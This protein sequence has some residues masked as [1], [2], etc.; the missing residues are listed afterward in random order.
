M[1]EDYY[2]GL[3]ENCPWSCGLCEGRSLHYTN[4]PLLP[5][6]LPHPHCAIHHAKLVCWTTSFFC[7][8]VLCVSFCVVAFQ[9]VYLSLLTSLSDISAPPSPYAGSP[10]GGSEVQA[11]QKLSA[12]GTMVC[13]S[14]DSVQQRDSYWWYFGTI[15][16]WDASTV[17]VDKGTY[18]QV[19]IKLA[20]IRHTSVPLGKAVFIDPARYRIFSPFPHLTGRP[21]SLARIN[22]KPLPPFLF[23]LSL[24]L[25]VYNCRHTHTQ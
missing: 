18:G 25:V 20:A 19:K 14:S 17:Y 4:P 2:A 10:M 8:V 9:H 7:L 24:S 5:S 1:P 16:T 3:V 13:L 12:Q 6:P 15:Q 22:W 11:S 23:P 21:S